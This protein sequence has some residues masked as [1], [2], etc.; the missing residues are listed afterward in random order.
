MKI[1]FVP[2]SLFYSEDLKLPQMQPRNPLVKGRDD[3][4]KYKRGIQL[5]ATWVIIKVTI[6][7]V[8]G[9]ILIALHIFVPLFLP[10]F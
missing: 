10:Y 9:N 1:M 8:P 7:S 2:P 4:S 3:R 5:Q 6:F